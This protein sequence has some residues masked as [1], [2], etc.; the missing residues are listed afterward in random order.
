MNYMIILG[1]IL[2]LNVRIVDSR[3]IWQFDAGLI[4]F[5]SI[6]LNRVTLRGTVN[7]IP[8]VLPVEVQIICHLNVPR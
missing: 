5:V 6:V 3:V 7:Q 1:Q 4:G 2:I 8:Y